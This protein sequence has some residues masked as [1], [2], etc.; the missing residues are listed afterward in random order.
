MALQ[1]FRSN[2]WEVREFGTAHCYRCVVWDLGYN[3]KSP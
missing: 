1:D 2:I 3:I